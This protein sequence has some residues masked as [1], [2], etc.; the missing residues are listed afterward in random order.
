MI[1]LV[2]FTTCALRLT[3]DL[4]LQTKSLLQAVQRWS[5]G[6]KPLNDQEIIV[7]VV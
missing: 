4:Q 6:G 5:C 7:F 2:H 3:Y 1:V